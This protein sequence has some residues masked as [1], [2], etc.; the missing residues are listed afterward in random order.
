MRHPEVKV[1]PYIFVDMKNALVAAAMVQ[2]PAPRQRLVNNVVA[3][4]RSYRALAF[5]VFRQP[6]LPA[7]GQEP[8]SV[9][10]AANVLAT[11]KLK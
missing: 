4:V 2:N 9:T 7:V 8:L 3:K 5:F 11:G 6:A 1:R 10:S